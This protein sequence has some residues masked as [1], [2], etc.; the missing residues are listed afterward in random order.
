MAETKMEQMQPGDIRCKIIEQFLQAPDRCLT[1][2]ALSQALGMTRAAI[3]KHIHVLEEIGF[4]FSAAPRVGYQLTSV[5]DLCLPPLVSATQAPDA[6]FGRWVHW[7]SVVDSTNRVAMHE[8]SEIPHGGIVTAVRQEGGR[9]RRGRP[10]ASPDG[11]LWMSLVLKE[12][13]P[14]TRAA[15]LTLLTSVAVRRAIAAVTGVETSIK[16][17]N[18]LMYNGRKLCGILAEIR[19]DGENVQHA[20]VGIGLNANVDTTLLPDEIQAIATSLQTITGSPCSLRA[21]MSAILTELEPLTSS[22]TENGAGFRGVAEE[23][24]EHSSTLGHIVTV[25]TPA[26]KLTGLADHADDQGVLYIKDESGKLH[27]IHSGDVLFA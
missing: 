18:D 6:R 21:L 17:P 16:W 2:A 14:L 7:F 10:W 24:R 20:V 4:A 1:G 27:A 26:G 12:P 15:E 19:A 9:G 3:W 8:I 11:G 13:L 22:L 5:P 23:W 25:Q